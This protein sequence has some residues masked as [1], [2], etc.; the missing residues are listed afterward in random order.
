MAGGAEE[1]HSARFSEPE[2][3]SLTAV[4][5]WGPWSKRARTCLQVASLECSFRNPGPDPLALSACEFEPLRNTAD[6]SSAAAS[7]SLEPSDERT[8][9]LAS[10]KVGALRIGGKG[11]LETGCYSSR[12]ILTTGDGQSMASVPVTVTVGAN[13][14]WAVGFVFLGLAFL[15]LLLLLAGRATLNE[16]LAAALTEQQQL[17]E[18]LESSPPTLADRPLARQAKQDVAAAIESLSQPRPFGIEDPRLTRAER[19]LKAAREGAATLREKIENKTPGQLAVDAMEVEWRQLTE[20]LA[21]AH[22]HL[23]P[24]SADTTGGERESG[25]LPLLQAVQREQWRQRLEPLPLAVKQGLGPHVD[26]AHLALVAGEQERARK[27]AQQ[28]TLWL[29]RAARQLDWESNMLLT[30]RS[31]AGAI[32]A[33]AVFLEQAQADSE[34]AEAARRRLGRSLAIARRLLEPANLEGFRDADRELQQA[35]TEL[36]RARSEQLIERLQAVVAVVDERTSLKRVEAAL[37]ELTPDVPKE[38]GISRVL[39]RWRETVASV[40]ETELREQLIEKVVNM[41]TL[42]EKG[43]LKAMGPAFQGLQEDW[44]GYQEE[45]TEQAMAA[46]IA[47]YCQ[48]QTLRLRSQHLA[49]VEALALLQPHPG[50]SGLEADLDLIDAE[51]EAGF[52]GADCLNP[53]TARSAELLQIGDRL[54]STYLLVAKLTPESRLASAEYSETAAAITLARRLMHEPWP[55][56]LEL[57]TPPEEIQVDRQVA[58]EVGDL[59]PSWGPGTSIRIDFGDGSAPLLRNAEEVRQEPL[60]QHRYPRPQRAEVRIVATQRTSEGIFEPRGETV[61]E[62][63]LALTVAPSPISLARSLASFFLS[64]RFALALAVGLL[65]QGWRLYDEHPFGSRSRDYLEAFA[66]GVGAQGLVEGFSAALVQ[67]ASGS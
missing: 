36:L 43:D 2:S 55:L 7:L 24:E 49:S 34:L 65:I 59:G 15:G 3:I 32:L 16:R 10:G 14:L 46:E 17:H 58:F 25:F 35:E 8:W 22:A 29:R 56:R 6:G 62:G 21:A 42:L 12:F 9:P 20:R 19:Y 53:L 31:F 13:W 48:Q 61:G 41:E 33:R 23:A 27:L 47:P 54:F 44:M 39:N 67:F 18:L 38:V 64:V 30:W 11:R 28:V 66:L 1:Q 52:S 51:L 60:L 40:E 50:V 37:D 63:R 4:H 57:R 5:P 26:R 45:Q